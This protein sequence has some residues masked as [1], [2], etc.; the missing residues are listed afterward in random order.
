[1]KTL[2]LAAL[3]TA[4]R[5]TA[6]AATV[7]I[8]PADAACKARVA[9]QAPSAKGPLSI[10]I[11]IDETRAVKGISYQNQSAAWRWIGI[12]TLLG[13]GYAAI[14]PGRYATEVHSIELSG[15]FKQSH[16]ILDEETSAADMIRLAVHLDDLRMTA[17]SKARAAKT[18]DGSE[19]LAGAVIGR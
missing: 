14:Y 13:S 7:E 6:G 8:L 16:T 4:L 11:C 10:V 3:M 1:M 2:W 9:Y 12:E 5:A 18:L 15:S 17:E 19:A